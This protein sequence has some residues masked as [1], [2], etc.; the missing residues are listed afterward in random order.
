MADNYRQFSF[1]LKLNNKK[2]VAWFQKILSKAQET[3]D[4][5]GTCADFDWSTDSAEPLHI[6]FRDNGGSGN[7]E[8]IAKFVE[9]YFKKFQPNGYFVVTWA[10]TCS[11]Q[12]TDEFG[13]GIAVV[14]ATGTAWFQEGPWVRK[15]TKGLEQRNTE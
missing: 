11:K 12:R 13:G 1:S 7:V 4:E 2:E 10:D 8:Q 3:D 5:W 6:W 14:K 9:K 15:Q